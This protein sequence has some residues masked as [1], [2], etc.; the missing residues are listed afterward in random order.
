[1]KSKMEKERDFKDFELMVITIY[2]I[3]FLNCWV[4]IGVV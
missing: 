4:Y 2:F 3:T 1:M